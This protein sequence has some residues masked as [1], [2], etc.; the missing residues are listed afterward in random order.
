MSYRLTPDEGLDA[1]EE[2]LHIIP[3]IN[4]GNKN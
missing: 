3:L 4:V 2:I 1:K